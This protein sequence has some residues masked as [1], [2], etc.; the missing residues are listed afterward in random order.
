MPKFSLFWSRVLGPTVARYGWY[1]VVIPLLLANI[2]VLQS[3]TAR[4][5]YVSSTSV[6]EIG[7]AHV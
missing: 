1:L 3:A 5:V 4:R 2:G 6:T 7:R